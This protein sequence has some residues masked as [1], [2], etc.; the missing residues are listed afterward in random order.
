MSSVVRAL[1]QNVPQ[2]FWKNSNPE[3]CFVLIALN[4][5]L[6]RILSLI[7]CNFHLFLCKSSKLGISS[8][9]TRLLTYMYKSL[10]CVYVAVL[11]QNLSLLLCHSSKSGLSSAFT[12][13]FESFSNKL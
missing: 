6:P 3:L 10:L 4:Q 1:G 12:I 11:I 13:L 5:K 8:D 9:F 7:M 2:H